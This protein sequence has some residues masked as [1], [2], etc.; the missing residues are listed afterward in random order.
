M[1]RL[2]WSGWTK[3]KMN[4]GSRL[5]NVRSR[6]DSSL[7]HSSGVG[8]G[9]A[10]MYEQAWASRGRAPFSNCREQQS[11]GE[12][13]EHNSVPHALSMMTPNQACGKALTASGAT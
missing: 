1:W 3:T 7:G 13:S 8:A 6:V 11:G 10:S 12:Q 5:L 2:L 9:V 4:G